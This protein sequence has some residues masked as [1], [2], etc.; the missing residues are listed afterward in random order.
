M[1]SNTTAPAARSW[2]PS[3]PAS[4]AA[5]VRSGARPAS[6][7]GAGYGSTFAQTGGGSRRWRLNPDSKHV[8]SPWTWRAFLFL[9]LIALGMAATLWAGGKDYYAAAWTVI[10]AGWLSISMW[11]WRRHHLATS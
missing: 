10:F 1:R 5:R 7:S 2:R 11:L 3:R 6:G 4:T 9:A 8:L